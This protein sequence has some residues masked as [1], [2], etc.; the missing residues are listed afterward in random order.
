MRG[1]I[2]RHQERC[3]EVRDQLSEHINGELDGERAAVVERHLRWC[4]NCR[5]MLANLERTVTALR[6][7]GEQASSGD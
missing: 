4:P 1:P 2:T 7:V 3:R 6:R 5:R